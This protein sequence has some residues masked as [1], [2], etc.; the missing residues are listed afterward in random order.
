MSDI[1]YQTKIYSDI[2]DN[3]RLHSLQSDIKL[4]PISLITDIEV[5]AHLCTHPSECIWIS[6][7]CS[8]RNLWARN[9]VSGLEGRMGQLGH[10][11]GKLLHGCDHSQGHGVPTRWPCLRA[12]IRTPSTSALPFCSNS[13]CPMTLLG[14]SKDTCC[15][16]LRIL[17]SSVFEN[18][19]ACTQSQAI[20]RAIVEKKHI[21][22]YQAE[23]SASRSQ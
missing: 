9:L 5:S 12:L 15:D 8:K 3:V 6:G 18:L 23:S 13:A 19:W 7:I 11:H 4:S 14:L 2:R 21:W 10:G 1:T 20:L 17:V 16:L 22:D